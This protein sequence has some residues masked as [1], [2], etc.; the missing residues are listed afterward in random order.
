MYW[1]RRLDF[2]QALVLLK[3]GYSLSR[4]AWSVLGMVEYWLLYTDRFFDVEQHLT[5]TTHP[6]TGN[7][8]VGWNPS[9]EDLFAED[10]FV[11]LQPT[12]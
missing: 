6:G 5:K 8:E 12:P 10:Y 9:R 3:A 2:S 4:R 1:D 11:V 7:I